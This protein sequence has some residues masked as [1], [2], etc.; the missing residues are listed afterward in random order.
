M[1]IVIHY[2]GLYLSI[3]ETWIY[4]QIKN[5]R[6]YCPIVYATS[7]EN[8]DIYPTEKIRSLELKKGLKDP[9][10][11][12]NAAWNK[13][14]TF[15]PY[16]AFSVIKDKPDLFHAHFGPSGYNFLTFKR[17][18]K[19][20]LITTFYGYDLSLLPS[21]HPKWKM[22]YK[23]LFREGEIFLV[24]GNHMK[25]CLIEL[26]CPEEKI[27]VQHLGIDLDLIKL[28]PRKL[29]E[30]REIKILISSSFREKKGIPYAI[31]AFGR[32]KQAHPDLK[33][34]LTIIGDSGGSPAEEAEREKI[35]GVIQKYNLKDCVNML[36]YQ[37]YPVFLRELYRHHIF[38]HP[39]V[40]ASD[41][42]TEGGAP[43]SIIEASASGMPILSTTHCDIPEVVIGG[44]S[45]YLV[46][47]KDVDALT[48]KL[49]FLVLNPEIWGQM[50]KKGRE[51]IEKNYDVI[52]QVQKLEEIYD[53]VL[54]R[55][56]E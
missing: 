40:H 27:I 37:P 56:I 12:F 38:L 48:D 26:G 49:E 8:L 30:E 17:I 41:G 4:G 11:F 42:D 9:Y 19:I 33:L 6:R 13:V 22:K 44:E 24:E 18:F 39:S 3:T 43:V 55:D 32:V 7:T 52:T 47:E 28:V 46:Q 51:H 36:G 34:N 1:R 23:K 50:G 29:G 53:K 20:P 25:K 10:T 45:G 5:L 15:Y 54:T 2:A 14:F 21:Q 16:F 31:E 35:F